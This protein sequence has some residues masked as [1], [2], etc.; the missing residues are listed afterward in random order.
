M[1]GVGV[2]PIAGIA[3]V[4][5]GLQ[6]LFIVPSD[7]LFALYFRKRS[8]ALCILATLFPLLVI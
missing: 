2:S 6:N 4:K 3:F 1:P 7:V 8:I 5:K